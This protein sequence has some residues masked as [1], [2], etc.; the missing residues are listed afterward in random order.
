MGLLNKLWLDQ[1]YT[2]LSTYLLQKQYRDAN[3]RSDCMYLYNNL[4][5]KSLEF[6]KTQIQNVYLKK[7]LLNLCN[8]RDNITVSC[9]ENINN[10]ENPKIKIISCPWFEKGSWTRLETNQQSINDDQLNK[11]SQINI[12]LQQLQKYFRNNFWKDLPVDILFGDYWVN[13]EN[14]NELNQQSKINKSVCKTIFW[15]EIQ[16]SNLSDHFWYLEKYDLNSYSLEDIKGI[17]SSYWLSEEFISWYL[18]SSIDKNPEVI[19]MIW[20]SISEHLNLIDEFIKHWD[21]SI[22][23]YI[24]NSQKIRLM[25]ELIKA[26][27]HSNILIW[28]NTY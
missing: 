5:L 2:E 15:E 20:L 19:N 14:H 28:I 1:Q 3:D 9:S 23:I 10:I 6:N 11:L 4:H 27:N 18:K 26:Q 24:G 13:V 22:L 8:I 21:N 16:F 7:T 17:I 25:N 12:I